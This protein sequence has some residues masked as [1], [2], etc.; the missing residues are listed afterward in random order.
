MV[1]DVAMVEEQHTV[2]IS[3]YL[4]EFKSVQCLAVS[5]VQISDPTVI[6]AIPLQATT[7]GR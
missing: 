5:D 7:S 6:E 1:W 4:P 2:E 3:G